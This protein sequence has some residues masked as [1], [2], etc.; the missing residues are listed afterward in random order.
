[1]SVLPTA[2]SGGRAAPGA[3]AKVV[4][5]TPSYRNDFQ[6]AVDL[7]RSVDEF[8]E[9]DFEHILIVPQR[10]MAMFSGLKGP[11]RRV[12]TQQSVLAAQGFTYLPLPT[13]IRIPPFLD[14]RLRQQVWCCGVG[15]ISG[16][17]TQQ[18]IKLS[19]SSL[20]DAELILFLDSDVLL[21]RPL[22]AER[23]RRGGRTDLHRAP[24][25]D[26]LHEHHGWYRTAREVLGV[27]NASPPP[28]NYIGQLITWNRSNLVRLHR[29]ISEV[30]G[31]PWQRALARRRNFAEYILYGVFCDEV[32]GAASGHA[33]Q[34][35]ELTHSVWTD[36]TALNAQSV[37]EGMQD[38]HVAL[39]MQSTLRLPIEQRRLLLRAV[40]DHEHA[41]HGSVRA[42]SREVA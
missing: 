1:M 21:F 2:A 20:S 17:V 36:A 13:Q 32:L 35:S 22:S 4:L 41:D 27:G 18:L 38:T 19:A 10:D 42:A 9:G 14:L 34:P 8:F 25:R 12:I 23:L 16:W 29:H 39:H 26:D 5:V 28:F 3:N 33:A 40:I 37:R 11:R 15:R 7:C 6:L 30:C 24:M 31:E